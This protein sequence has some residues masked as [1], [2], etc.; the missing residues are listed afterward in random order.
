MAKR[1]SGDL[2]ISVIYD[3]R[4]FYR[5]AVSRGGKL[6]W[7][8]RVRPPAAGFGRGIAY[9]SPEAYDDTARA[10]LSFMQNEFDEGG[11]TTYD[12]ASHAEFGDRGF[13][14]RRVPRFHE[15]YPPGR[16]RPT[17]F[18]LRD[19]QKRSLSLEEAARVA[20]ERG[21]LDH[22]YYALSRDKTDVLSDLYERTRWRQSASSAAMGRSKLYSFHLALDREASRHS[23]GRDRRR[24]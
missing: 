16:V 22:D 21:V 7:R 17:R 1:Y 4:D 13:V 9:D 23:R 11:R 14:V 20:K 3:D 15:Q 8:G 18:A 19:R 12:A 2:Q 6:L 24:A 5:V 10:A